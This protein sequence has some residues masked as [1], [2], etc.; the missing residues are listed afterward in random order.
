M[1][2]V[3]GVERPNPRVPAVR[4]VPRGGIQPAVDV[5]RRPVH[6]SCSVMHAQEAHGAARGKTR[7]GFAIWSQG[8]GVSSLSTR[9]EVV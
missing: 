1:R 4:L 6:P 7:C 2:I 9:N 5:A 3:V 8:N